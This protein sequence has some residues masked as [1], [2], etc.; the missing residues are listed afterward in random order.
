MKELLESASIDENE[1]VVEEDDKDSEDDD[2]DFE[3]EEGEL[4][5]VTPNIIIELSQQIAQ[6]AGR[7]SK[8]NC[9]GKEFENVASKLA[10]VNTSLCLAHSRYERNRLAK[11]QSKALRQ[12]C[13]GPFFLWKN[14]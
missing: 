12:A 13:L 7:M 11:K 9:D 14:A 6:I 5:D 10:D 2:D 8:L 3:M 4:T 1:I